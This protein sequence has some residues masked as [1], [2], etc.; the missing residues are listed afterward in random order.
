MSSTHSSSAHSRSADSS[1]TQCIEFC[2][3]EIGYGRERVA[4]PL[5]DVWH[6]GSLIA[7]TGPNGAGKT[8]L[9]R[10]LLG[11]LRPLAGSIARLDAVRVGYVPQLTR[12]DDGFPVTVDEV[13]GTARA[14]DGRPTRDRREQVLAAV[15][16]AAMRQCKFFELSGGQ[17][18]RVL[19]AR[20]LVGDADIVA[21][22]E[23][24]AGVD[25]ESAEAIW[26]LLRRTVDSGRSVVVVTHDLHRLPEFADRILELDGGVMREPA[27]D[28]GEDSP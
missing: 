10:T 11:F 6:H 27:V 23:P 18:Q 15:D 21:L 20:A 16:M 12:F 26:K 13:L 19:L 4:G 7:L 9:L 8:T 2:D 24:T 25:R 1:H 5:N 28:G 14:A 17:R 22:D 3:L